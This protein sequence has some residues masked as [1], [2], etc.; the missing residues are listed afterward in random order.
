[1]KTLDARR[2]QPIHGGEYGVISTLP[3]SRGGRDI[4]GIS[5]ARLLIVDDDEEIRTQM[6]WALAKDYDIVMAGDRASA[7]ADHL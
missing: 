5:L 7:L 6:K 1:M 3:V 2:R 4:N